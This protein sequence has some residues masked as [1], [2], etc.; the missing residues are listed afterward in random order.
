MIELNQLLVTGNL[1]AAPETRPAGESSVTRGRILHSSSY[2]D[3]QTG[4]RK[5][6]EPLGIDFEIWNGYGEAFAQH[7]GKGTA[8]L[9]EGEL[10][11]N[12]YEREDGSM[13]F[14]FRLRVDRWQIVAQPGERR[15][16]GE[17]SQVEAPKD[18]APTK[19]EKRGGRRSA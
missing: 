15:T 13:S 11:P 16:G 12:N 7:V 3:R 6:T 2:R 1:V 19:S 8:V 10:K 9:L 17:T 14:G 18:E 4:E 5:K